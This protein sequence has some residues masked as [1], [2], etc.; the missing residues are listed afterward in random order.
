MTSDTPD[1]SPFPLR[2]GAIDVG[3]NAIRSVAAEFMDPSHWV[4]LEY[5]RYPVRLGHNVFLTRELDE[6]NIAATV[7]AMSAF[8]RSIDTFGLSRYR[9]VATSAVR[10]SRNGGELVDRIRGECG[11][12]L[13]T[14]TGSE[15][16]RLAWLAV[17]NRID[18]GDRRW[19]LTD[20]GGGSLEVALVSSEG[21]H[22][23]ESHQMGTV[24]L[25]EDLDAA[26]RTPD[27]FRDL[28]A[29]FVGTLRLPEGLDKDPP[30]GL[31]ATGGNIEALARLGGFPP[32]DTGVGRLP[33]GV[34]R[35]WTEKLAG[36]SVEERIDELDLR[37]D[38][39]D[40]IL[41]AALIHERVAVLVG[42]D[43]FIVPFTGVSE[44][45]LLDLVED[46]IGPSVH[47]TRMERQ[48]FHGALAL[49][50]RFRF[51]EAH[52]R[53]VARLSLSLF[54]QLR[55]LHGLDDA[56][57]RVLLGAAVLHDVGLFLSH[58]KH[59]KHS[60][61]LIHNSELP[62]FTRDE[63]PL[64]ALVARYHRRAEPKN[65][66]YLYGTLTSSE[67]SRVRRMSA[68]LRVAD[69]LD[70]EHLQRVQE[71]MAHVDGDSLVI[72]VV[73]RGDLLLEQWA[74]TKKAKMFKSVFGADV[75]L[76]LAE[77]SLGPGVI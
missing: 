23:I 1:R 52:G 30:A 21:I 13:E 60:L 22:W 27:Q 68:L 43:E 71:V 61:Y 10:E 64:V 44:G 49:G 63:I 59:H 73:G 58:R 74:L 31:I 6:T 35:E 4:V 15:E 25:L 9:A 11:I 37:H 39:A 7:E 48:A 3:S 57:R 56:D 70:R 66:H 75:R 24:R 32:D 34:L 76:A 47:A 38:R 26:G 45:L 46:L 53:H 67:Q 55:D 19:I 5:Q 42:A 14:I 17:R 20:L 50:R 69:A 65:E 16:S 18:M 29:E 36:M 8:R 51:D 54:D 33:I 41:P 28:V 77:P 72:H 40:V 2:V 62:N 12:R